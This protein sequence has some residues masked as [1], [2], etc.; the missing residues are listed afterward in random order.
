[1][2]MNEPTLACQIRY[3]AALHVAANLLIM[4]ILILAWVVR[5]RLHFS[6]LLFLLST[7]ILMGLIIKR[8]NQSFVKQSSQKSLYFTLSLI[9]YGAIPITL[10]AFL[11]FIAWCFWFYFAFMFGMSQIGSSAPLDSGVTD[12]LKQ[13]SRIAELLFSISKDTFVL[14]TIVQIVGIT[15]GSIKAFRGIIYKYPF[16]IK[17]SK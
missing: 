3:S 9:I 16:A 2:K 17:F 14:L 8:C 15:I 7:S 4:P 6:S 10:F 12:T 5:D 13:I 11:S 1:M